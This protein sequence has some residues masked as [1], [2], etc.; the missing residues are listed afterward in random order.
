LLARGVSVTIDP[1]EIRAII[2][3]GLLG[4]VVGGRQIVS[5]AQSQLKIMESGSRAVE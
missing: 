4:L 3:H 5:F 1:G 2:S